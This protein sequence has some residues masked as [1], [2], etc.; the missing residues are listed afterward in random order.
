MRDSLIKRH[1]DGLASGKLVAHRCRACDK[2]TY[3]ILCA[4]LAE[5]DAHVERH[6]EEAHNL[7]K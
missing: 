6:N 1:Y 3:P 5:Q 7:T 2:L 4:W